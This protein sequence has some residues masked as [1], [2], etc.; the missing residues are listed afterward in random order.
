M[1]EFPKS[2]QA[3]Q[4]SD[5]ELF[6]DERAARDRQD[7]IDR[8]KRMTEVLHGGGSVADA[9][10]AVDQ[11][12]YYEAE[13]DILSQITTSAGI[14]IEHWQCRTEPGYSVGDALKD[15]MLWV[16]G[17][18]GS[19]SG[20]YGARVSLDDLIRYAKATAARHGGRLPSVWRRP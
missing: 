1:S 16:G 17:D 10:Q 6:G 19:W 15:G 2:I 9:L 13:R 14:T 5:G 4:S 12:R 18:A 11:M 3:W 7:S 8:A 20:G